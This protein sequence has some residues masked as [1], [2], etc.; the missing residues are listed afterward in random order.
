M[1]PIFQLTPSHASP[2]AAYGEGPRNPVVGFLIKLGFL[3]LGLGIVASPLLAIFF[4][5][6]PVPEQTVLLGFSGKM[7]G[8]SDALPE[9]WRAS[10]RE[11]KT[12]I[13]VGATW[14]TDHA[15]AFAIVPR[16]QKTTAAWREDVGVFSLIADEALTKTMNHRLSAFPGALL[17]VGRGHGYVK[18]LSPTDERASLQGEIIGRTVVLEEKVKTTPK[19]LPGGDVS[20]DLEALPTAWGAA[21]AALEQGHGWKIEEKP[22][23]LGLTLDENGIQSA[24]FRYQGE[25]PVGVAQTMLASFGIFDVKREELPDGTLMDELV[26][27]ETALASST[28]EWTSPTGE[29][30]QLADNRLLIE[31]SST[32]QSQRPVI[33]T[34]GEQTLAYFS[35]QATLRAIASAG[36]SWVWPFGPVRVGITRDALQICVD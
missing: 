29:L 1:E 12:P 11:A 14:K 27:P 8:V 20:L 4:V 32:T 34:C 6:L 24:E 17:A 31:S 10:L 16:F 15:V 13:V 19:E 2:I 33:E 3:M 5:P 18:L 25:V 26:L 22:E 35:R 30:I 9:I 21:Q 23:S 28:H 36:Q 7:T